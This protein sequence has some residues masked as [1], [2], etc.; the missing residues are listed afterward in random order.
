MRIMMVDTSLK[1]HHKPYLKVLVENIKHDMIAV[2]PEIDNDIECNQIIYSTPV[3]NKRTLFSYLK[4]I[5]ELQFIAIENNVDVIHFLYGDFL[6]RY[7]SLGLSM[8]K[9]FK[10]V[11]TFHHMP[12]DKIRLRSVMRI[13]KKISIG[14]IHTKYIQN[15][16]IENGIKNVKQIE[17]PNFHETQRSDMNPDVTKPI[18]NMN[19]PVIAAI[20]E[21]RENKGLDILLEALNEVKQPFNLLIAGKEVYFTR[22][23]IEGKI[24]NYSNNVKIILKYLSDDE[25]K[26]CYEY[27][28]IIVLP[29]KKSFGGASGP[30]VEGVWYRKIIIGPNY[31]SIGEII[32]QHHLGYVFEV[33]NSES[34]A[35]AIEKALKQTNNQH[36]KYEKFR[37]SL[38]VENFVL[39]YCTL[40]SNQFKK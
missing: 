8:L 33:E 13:F 5:K 25:L 7:F 22:E 21:T 26:L 6:Y 1:G 10:T 12:E 40:Y 17:Y 32:K 3:V 23:F 14:V 31:K 18:F 9:D 30:L 11:V 4:W 27:S 19:A 36:E 16:L 2:L 34:L 39:E 29:Y 35:M 37:E 28:D 20:G 24:A 15:L 38:S